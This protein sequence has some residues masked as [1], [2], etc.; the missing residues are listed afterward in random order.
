MDPFFATSG[1]GPFN[2][3]HDVTG[4]PRLDTNGGGATISFKTRS[5]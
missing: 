5:A 2:V 4:Y 1:S 3:D